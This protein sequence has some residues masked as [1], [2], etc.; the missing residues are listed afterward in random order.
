VDIT[1][2]EVSYEGQ[3]VGT[4]ALGVWNKSDKSVTAKIRW[5]STSIKDSM[6]GKTLEVQFI[7]ELRRDVKN[8]TMEIASMDNDGTV[9]FGLST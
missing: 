1:N 3:K 9:Y 5:K 7:T 8:Q 4:A 6:P 2:I